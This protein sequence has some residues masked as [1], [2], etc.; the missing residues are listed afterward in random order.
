MVLGQFHTGDVHDML[1]N[2]SNIYGICSEKSSLGLAQ[3][4][5]VGFQTYCWLARR[6]R[7]SDVSPHAPAGLTC[8]PP[9]VGNVGT[10]C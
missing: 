2:D 9:A 1:G 10:D 5:L 6:P 4:D 3:E 7:R 8:L